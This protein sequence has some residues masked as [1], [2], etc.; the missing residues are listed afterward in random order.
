MASPSN[1]S[2]VFLLGPRTS[3]ADFERFALANGWILHEDRPSTGPKDAHEQSWVTPDRGTAIHYMDDPTPKQR[4]LVVYG[5]DTG[6]VSF[7]LGAN[8]DITTPIDVTERALLASTDPE[9]IDA[10]W[11]LAVVTK[12]YDEATLDLLK[13]LYYD[14]S[15]PVRHAVVNAVGYR[16]WPEARGFLEEVARDDANPE[17]RENARAIVKAWWGDQAG[18]GDTAGES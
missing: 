17:L 18:T 14:A 3:H 10:A 4:F 1:E 12:D 15:D 9:R 7:D 2:V 5:R 11:Q 8:F 16:G 6:A 13:S